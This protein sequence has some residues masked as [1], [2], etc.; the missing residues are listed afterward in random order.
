MLR[1]LDDRR[2]ELIVRAVRDLLA[3]CLVTLPVLLER[4]ATASLDF[5]FSNFDG[6]RRSLAPQL[7]DARTDGNGTIDADRLQEAVVHGRAQWTSLAIEIVGRWRQGG[8]EGVA[9]L[10][11]ALHPV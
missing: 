9:C 1:Q 3:D 6:V 7:I 4:R 8:P 10:T 11:K 5:W 2:T